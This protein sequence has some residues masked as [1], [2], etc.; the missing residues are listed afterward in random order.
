LH[1]DVVIV[2]S[3]PSQSKELL[4]RTIQ[5]GVGIELILHRKG[6]ANVNNSPGFRM[7]YQSSSE[8]D[9]LFN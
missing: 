3:V 5:A 9:K 2:I 1:K 4:D 7:P 6:D 8:G